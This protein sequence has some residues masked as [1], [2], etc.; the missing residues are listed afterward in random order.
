MPTNDSLT[1]SL[2]RLMTYRKFTADVLP[3]RLE[4][5]NRKF[6][7][8]QR[9]SEHLIMENKQNLEIQSFV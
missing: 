5:Q 9:F 7:A 3:G 6:D 2:I 8:R 1:P 4:H